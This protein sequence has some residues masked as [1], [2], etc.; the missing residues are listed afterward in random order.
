MYII[1]FYS[2]FFLIGCKVH[3]ELR[4]LVG[5]NFDLLNECGFAK[6]FISITEKDKINIIQT[7][8]LHDVLLRCKAELDQFAEG[9]QSC[10]VLDAIRQNPDLARN[11]FCIGR[12]KKLISGVFI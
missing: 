2:D 1:C 4:T 12:R 9:L 5:S 10:G 6:P 11:Y 3:H 8:A 7:L